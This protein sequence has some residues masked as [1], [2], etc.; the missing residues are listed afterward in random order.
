M[1]DASCSRPIWPERTQLISP[2]LLQLISLALLRRD[3]VRQHLLVDGDDT[4]W[5]NNIYFER[6]IAAFIAFL[7]HS[8]L[9]PDEVRHVINEMER[10]HGYGT[11]NFARSLEATYRRLVEREVSA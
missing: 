2:A 9:T 7:A 11:E 4:L 8:T 5:E 6:T 1:R 10:M 3:L